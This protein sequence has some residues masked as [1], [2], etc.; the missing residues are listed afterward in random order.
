MRTQGFIWVFFCSLLC[1][2]RRNENKIIITTYRAASYRYIK[3][4]VI[5][6]CLVILLSSTLI[7]AESKNADSFLQPGKPCSKEDLNVLTK[8]G[9]HNWIYP[10]KGT[11]N[12]CNK[13][14]PCIS[15]VVDEMHVIQD[16][17]ANSNGNNCDEWCELFN[18]P[19]FFLLWCSIGLALSIPVCVFAEKHGVFHLI[20]DYITRPIERWL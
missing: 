19:A 2:F 9:G 4:S 3:A 15:S 20:E 1:N 18:H 10:I 16:S 12:G 6:P 11:I 13:L 8:A 7:Y 17:T 5:I 14:S